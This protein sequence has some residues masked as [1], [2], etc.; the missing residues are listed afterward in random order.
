MLD[1]ESF[2]QYYPEFSDISEGR[3]AAA[4]AIANALSSEWLGLDEAVKESA[5]HLLLA[6]V[7]AIL[8]DGASPINMYET[9]ESKVG[10]S[11]SLRNKQNTTF[12]FHLTDYG[13]LLTDILNMGY[14]GVM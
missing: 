3:F 10:L 1:Q 2:N 14:F 6:H 4:T 9:K 8:S 12:N 7:L 5:D 11:T 13:L